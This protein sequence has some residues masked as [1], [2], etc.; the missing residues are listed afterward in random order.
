MPGSEREDQAMASSEGADAAELERVAAAFRAS[1]PNYRDMGSPL[2]AALCTAAADDPAL[3]ALARG[4][5]GGR[6]MLLLAAVHHM[7]LADPDQPLARFFATLTPKPLPPQDAF[8][9]FAR[10]CAEHREALAARLASSTIQSTFVERCWALAPALA[11]VA[12]VAGEPLNLVEIGCSAGVLLTFDA[13]A[14]DLGAAGRI[15]PADAPLT[16]TGRSTGGPRLRIPRIVTRIGLDLNPIDARSPEA[17]RW[18]LALCF[19]EQREQQ[20][21]LATALDVVARSDIRFLRGEALELLPQA[22]A[23]TAGP[24]CVFSSSCLFYWT[25]EAREAL[26]RLLLAASEER[27]IFRVGLEAS[28]RFDSWRTGR[29]DTPEAQRLARTPNELTIARYRQGALESRLVAR[30]TPDYQTVEWVADV[31]A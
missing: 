12:E 27:E 14:Y 15:G 28:D 10:F 17:R 21:R 3:M 5:Q 2:Y 23:E 26:D 22:L 9:A 7:L 18:L 8:P 29:A 25:A 13:Y 19:P 31:W 6:P 24:L 11:L 30:T 1:A 4:G 20:A 16:I